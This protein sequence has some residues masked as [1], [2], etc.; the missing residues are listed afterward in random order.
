MGE[1]ISTGGSL[2]FLPKLL[3]GLAGLLGGVSI[4][5]FWSARKLKMYSRFVA[6]AITGGV[7]VAASITLTGLIASQLNMNSLDWDT[8]LGIGYLVGALSIGFIS[9][10]ANFLSS[11]EDK[12]IIEVA[13][14]IAGRG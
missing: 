3:A 4:S 5:F 8:S 10:L 12:D 9:L 13:K 11:R 7:S 1:P 2:F 14:E 6:G